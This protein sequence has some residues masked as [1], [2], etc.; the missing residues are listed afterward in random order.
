MPDYASDALSIPRT[1]DP[2][3]REALVAALP[4]S[5][6]WVACAC[7]EADAYYCDY[8]RKFLR[9]VAQWNSLPSEKQIKHLRRAAVR[10]LAVQS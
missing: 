6:R 1:D 2:A 4:A 10:L 8:D 3:F 9:N 7:L 5:W